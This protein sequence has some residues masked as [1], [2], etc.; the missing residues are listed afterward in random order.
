MRADEGGPGAQQIDAAR[1]HA[2]FDQARAVVGDRFAEA[3]VR[4]RCGGLRVTVVD[5]SQCD[6]AV[7]G[8][9]AHGLGIVGR[10]STEGADPAALEM[11]ERLQHELRALQQTRPQFC[12]SSIR[13]P[14]RGIGVHGCRSS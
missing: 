13:C 3:R 2:L 9:V 11:W 1:S 14:S 6:V 8:A 7:I 5:L 10:V 4:S 12:C